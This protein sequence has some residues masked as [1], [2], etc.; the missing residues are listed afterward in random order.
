MTAWQV[1]AALVQVVGWACVVPG[2][3]FAAN[4]VR[5]VVSGRI[6][7]R[8]SSARALRWGLPLLVIGVVLVFGGTW[9]ANW[10]V[11]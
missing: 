4:G 10:A 3:F 8:Q 5:I 9:L 6:D 11:H 1:V 2:L 7:E